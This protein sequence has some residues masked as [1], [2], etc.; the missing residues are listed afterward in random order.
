M[1]RYIQTN[2]QR[3]VLRA[4]KGSLKDRQIGPK[5]VTRYNAALQRFFFVLP[6]LFGAWGATWEER[7]LQLGSC[8]EALWHDGEPRSQAGD[9]LFAL[10]W[11]F[12]VQKVFS[13]AWR[14][15]ATR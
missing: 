1:L 15:F 13:C 11:H 5:C 6:Y 7:D 3:R 10:Q 2:A 4:D 12:C 14:K 8:I 9:I